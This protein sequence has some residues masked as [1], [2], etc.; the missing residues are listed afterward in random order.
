MRRDEEGGPVID[1]RHAVRAFGAVRPGDVVLAAVLVALGSWLMVLNVVSDDP[2][3]RIDSRSWWMLPLFLAACVPVLWWRRRL[4]AV[5]AVATVVMAGHDVL[6]GHLVRCGAGL[7]LAFVLAFLSGRGYE[8]RRGLLG[9]ALTALLACA[10]LV[11][12]TAAGPELIPVALLILAL[13]WGIGQVVRNRSSLAEELARRNQELRTLRDER[14]ALEV[15]DDRARVSQQLEAMLDERLRRLEA[16]ATDGRHTD[17]A[18]LDDAE[19]TRALLVTLENDSRRTLEDMRQ[20]VGVL[21]GGEVSLAPT[22]SVAH[23]DALLARHVRTGLTV[24]GDPRVLSA[25]VELSAYRIVEHLITALADAPDAPVSVMLRFAEDALEIRVSGP[26]PRGADL[27]AA[28]TRARERAR[29][30][31]GSL[32]A[33]ISRGRARVVAQLPVLDG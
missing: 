31:A 33:K 22:P 5:L 20:I 4:L 25:S 18:G 1:R 24:S 28:V 11:L 16:A 14:T 29:L 10:V 27:R 7:P 13:L 3:T 26:V 23:L 12:D 8:R 32:E 19:R 9:L 21:R 30:H 2:T 17:G 15:A 6:F